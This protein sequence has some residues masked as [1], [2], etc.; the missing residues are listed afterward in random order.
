[1]IREVLSHFH[2]P[3]LTCIGLFLFLTVFV[4]CV[5]WVCRKS[6][7]KFYQ[8]METLPLQEDHS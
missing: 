7:K 5:F 8:Y 1:M 4:S 3:F 2:L 6:G